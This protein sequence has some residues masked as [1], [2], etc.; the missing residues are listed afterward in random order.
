MNYGN[1]S[2]NDG[3]FVTYA[4]FAPLKTDGEGF[5]FYLGSGSSGTN[6]LNGE[7]GIQIAIDNS[8]VG[9]VTGGTG[10]SCGVDVGTG[11]EIA[12][13]AFVFDWDFEGLEITDVS[14]CAFINGTGHDYISNQVMAGMPP[15]D[16]LGEPRG[17]DFNTIPGD[18]FARMG[19]IAKAC[20]EY[21]YG[22]C[23]LGD[24]CVVTSEDNCNAGSGDFLGVDSECQEET[25]LPPDCAT[26]INDDGTTNVDD[27]LE[28]LAN[29]GQPCI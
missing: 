17:L 14:V 24:V 7:N 6:V 1:D 4:N 2:N 11:I 21:N 15:M 26:D 12:I 23:C 27:L 29:Y 28:L 13:P 5:G 9:G 25:C 20:P 3:A 22:A 8:N 18:Q 10:S 19:D 16:S